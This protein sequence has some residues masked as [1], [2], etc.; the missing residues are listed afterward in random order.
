[1]LIIPF[2]RFLKDTVIFVCNFVMGMMDAR[3]SIIWLLLLMAFNTVAYRMTSFSKEPPKNS[4]EGFLDSAAHFHGEGAADCELICH[5]K[6][7]NEEEK[8][9]DATKKTR[10]GLVFGGAF[11]PF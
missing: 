8:Y 10:R 2:S 6:S 9:K 4:E 1:M 5:E 3:R 7:R 11:P